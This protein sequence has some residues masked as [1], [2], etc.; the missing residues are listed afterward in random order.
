MA[1]K[2][3]INL[4]HCSGQKFSYA[5]KTVVWKFWSNGVLPIVASKFSYKFVYFSGARRHNKQA[6]KPRI[7]RWKSGFARAHSQS[8]GRPMNL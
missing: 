6:N 4:L 5:G 3:Y 7:V 8:C 2:Y 1:N